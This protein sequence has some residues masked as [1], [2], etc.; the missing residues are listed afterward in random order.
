VAEFLQH[1]A[2]IKIVMTNYLARFMQ[3]LDDVRKICK[4]KRIGVMEIK[5][6]SEI[7]IQRELEPFQ[8]DLVKVLKEI[9]LLRQ[10]DR[11]IRESAI[12]ALKILLKLNPKLTVIMRKFKMQVLI[13][14]IIEREFKN[15]AVAKERLQCFKF[16]KAWLFNSADNFPI[17]FAQAIVGIVR[18]EE[19]F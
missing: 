19:E 2:D 4:D 7:L 11:S 14:F 9:F 16:M 13:T 18:N 5:Y 15:N 17:F 12:K 10:R 6:F 3:L 1:K 8:Y